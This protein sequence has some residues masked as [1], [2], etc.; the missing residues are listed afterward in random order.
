MI[1]PR[2]EAGNRIADGRVHQLV[3]RFALILALALTAVIAAPSAR[4]AQ[5][6]GDAPTGRMVDRVVA[7]VND[8]II[9]HSELMRRVVPMAAELEQISDPRERER[10]KDK[11]A[12]QVLEEMVN[13]ELV[14]QAAVDSKLEVSAKEVQNAL[15]DIK[16]QNDLDDNQLAEALRMQGYSMSGYREDLRRQILRMR[17]VNTLVRPKVSVTDED[18][19]ARFDAQSR[20][21]AAVSE[22][23]L[24]H[25]LI[26]VPE[27]P[28]AEQLAD[29][30]ARAA[31]VIER[32]RAGE[33]F[34]KLAELYSDDPATRNTGGELGWIQ[35]G[36]IATEWEVIVF[37]MD[38]GETRGP[39]NGP[40]GLHV[41][42]VAEVKKNQ[43]QPFEEAKD[44]LRNEMYREEMDRQSRL[45]IDDLRKQAHVEIKL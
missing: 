30:K 21:A 26:A 39:I 29:A 3:P 27:K 35:R 11:L 17:A 45:W 41:F 12:S 33:D 5:G 36:S 43:Q 32:A 20:R 4:A 10:R 7:I 18:V 19:K 16:Q 13:E 42:H 15:D 34:A 6:D 38:E 2:P 24:Q 9:L 31:E 23:K 8:D 25:V 40:R 37:S 44:Q 1:G 22:V 28:S 14:V